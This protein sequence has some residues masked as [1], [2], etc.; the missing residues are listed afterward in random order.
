MFLN[1]SIRRQE[2]PCPDCPH[3]A[4][5]VIEHTLLNKMPLLLYLDL[6]PDFR[7]A[8]VVAATELQPR[9]NPLSIGRRERNIQSAA[10]RH[11]SPRG[12]LRPAGGTCLRREPRD[13][14]KLVVSLVF[15]VGPV[16]GVL[17][18]LVAELETF[19]HSP[20]QRPS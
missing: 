3:R 12:L 14:W 6:V 15:I 2:L 11:R 1:A 13:L 10:V 5:Q 17:D 8:A 16:V 7:E 20:G 4:L 9:H 18:N 19:P